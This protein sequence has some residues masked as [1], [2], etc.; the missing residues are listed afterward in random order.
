MVQDY[1]SLRKL[2][3]GD[4]DT[5]LPVKKIPPHANENSSSLTPRYGS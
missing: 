4:E 1:R 3:D 5:D 2:A